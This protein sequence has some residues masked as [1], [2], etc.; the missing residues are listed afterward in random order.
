M[1]TTT[2]C[3]ACGAGI[4]AGDLFCEACGQPLTAPVTCPGCA[5]TAP[6]VDGYCGVCGRKEPA[7]RNH[8]E[9]ELPDVPVAGV[10]DKGVRHHRNEDAMAVVAV[11]GALVAVV[12]DGVSTTVRPDEASQLAVDSAAAVLA[13]TPPSTGTA[14]PHL[15]AY[16]AA[17]AAV[18]TVDATPAPD[19]GPPSCTYLAAVATNARISLAH[20][21]DC[22]AYWR[23]AGGEVRQ[24]TV[25][26][27]WATQEVA[28]GRMPAS[29]AYADVRAHSITA[30][31]G[32]DA[33][34]A[35][36][37]ALVQ[38]DVAPEGG[39][40]LL[41]SDGLWNYTPTTGDVDALLDAGDAAPLA[42]AR[43]LVDHANASGGADNITVVVVDLPL[44]PPKG[45]A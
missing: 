32:A 26:D 37:P 40:L 24:L 33:D 15:A 1:A 31:L 6:F 44:H 30:W 20:L 45:T 34:P 4:A 7:P 19:L 42:T 16:D 35:W 39:R 38:V 22:R 21:G 5:S 12:C 8:L 25:D 2:A 14:P 3:G 10:T 23:P 27:S 28:A 17:R 36:T 11:E 13:A 43:R 41:V 18:L 29:E 9:L